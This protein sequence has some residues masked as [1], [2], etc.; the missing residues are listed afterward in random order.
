MRRIE[1]LLLLVAAASG[2]DPLH[3]PTPAN[4]TSAPVVEIPRDAGATPSGACD[5]QSQTSTQDAL[6]SLWRFGLRESVSVVTATLESTAMDQDGMHGTLLVEDVHRGLAFLRGERVTTLIE[7]G[8]VDGRMLPARF[9]LG[10]T[11]ATPTHWDG[12]AIPWLGLVLAMVPAEEVAAF[13]DVTGYLAQAPHIAVVRVVRREASRIAFEIVDA[14]RGTFPTEVSINLD[15]RAGLAYPSPS[16]AL[17]IVSISG[18]SEIPAAQLWL[19]TVDDWR[20]ATAENLSLVREAIAQPQVSDVETLRRQRER[21]LTGF[22]FHV[23]PFVASS[24]VTGLA[25]ECCTNAGG[26]FVAHDVTEV[27]RGAPSGRFILGGHAYYGGEQ[28]GDGFLVGLASVAST[29]PANAEGGFDC[30]SGANAWPAWQEDIV[31]PLTV[32]LPLSDENLG[33]VRGW[34]DASPPVYRLLSVDSDD[35]PAQSDNAPW[36]IPVDTADAFILATGN[37][38][39]TVD[40]VRT[41]GEVSIIRITTTLSRYEYEWLPRH[42]FNIAFRCGDARLLERGS[43]WVA[44]IVSLDVDGTQAFIIPGSI[45]P[46]YA[47]TDALAQSLELHLAQ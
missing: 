28:C 36:S 46:E 29:A 16:D 22:R 41:E 38:L 7:P 20:P 42:T 2:C 10:V 24:V 25:E 33:A 27:L 13:S 26:T 15:E 3:R 32:R 40:D 47:V 18:L 34:L 23:A 14:L 4:E 12:S 31:S 11:N 1:H 43:R 9:V 37:I 17:H 6:R 35:A 19:G 44:A 8:A 45:V 5:A 39:F 21:Y 30:V